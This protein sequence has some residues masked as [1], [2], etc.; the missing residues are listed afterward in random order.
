MI[1]I[2]DTEIAIHSFTYSPT[3]DGLHV[4]V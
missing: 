3:Y 4:Q 1:G 2:Q